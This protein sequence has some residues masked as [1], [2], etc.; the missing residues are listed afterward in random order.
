MHNIF[1]A[2]DNRHIFIT[3]GEIK[4]NY[5]QEYEKQSAELFETMKR[6]IVAQIMATCMVEL[7]KEFGFGKKRLGRFKRGVEWLFIA[8]AGEGIMGK[9]FTTQNCID[10][11]RDQYAIDV[12]VKEVEE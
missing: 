7:N 2:D 12:D 9:P 6:D 4:K 1:D 11:I 10:Y 5:R 3:V 8:M